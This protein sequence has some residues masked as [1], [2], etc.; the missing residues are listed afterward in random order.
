MVENEK[1]QTS[2]TGSVQVLFIDKT[3]L[4]V[5]PNSTLIIDRFVYNPATTKGEVALSLSRGVLRVVGGI[6]THT[7][8]ATVGTP[9]ASFGVR[10]GIATI[11]HGPNGS[12]AIL[13]FGHLTATTFCARTAPNCHPKTV[14]VS[15]P[16]YG[17]TIAGPNQDPSPPP[18]VS[19]QDIAKSNAQLSS[20]SGQTGGASQLPTDT[21]AAG[22][23]VGTPNSPVAPIPRPARPA[24][25]NA[26]QRSCSPRNRPSSKARKPQPRSTPQRPRRNALSKQR[27]R[28]LTRRLR[29]RRRSPPRH[30]RPRRRAHDHLF[31]RHPR[32][33]QHDHGSEPVPYLTGA[34]AGTGGFTVTPILGYQAAA[35]TERHVPT[36]PRDNFRRASA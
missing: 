23:D 2:A 32:A 6:A 29:H 13:G 35:S 16:G 15:R 21:Q 19:S 24:A 27:P 30:R 33:L 9:L 10:G 18:R 36:R 28:S 7:G 11:S 1:I 26:L 4:N 17:V 5:G 3:T 22:Y 14:E 20:R 31:H 8:G 34:F 25:R 12:Q